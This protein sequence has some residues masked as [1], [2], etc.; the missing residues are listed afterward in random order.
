MRRRQQFRTGDVLCVGIV[1]REC[2]AEDGEQEKDN[3]DDQADE[4][5]FIADEKS[6]EI[7]AKLALAG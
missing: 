2:L 4:I 1:W 5:E 6:L 3:H 7:A